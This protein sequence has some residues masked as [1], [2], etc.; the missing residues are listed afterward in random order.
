MMFFHQVTFTPDAQDIPKLEKNMYSINAFEYNMSLYTYSY[1]GYGLMA[2]RKEILTRDS[3][4]L[5]N[6]INPKEVVEV[7]SEC[8]NPIVTTEWSYSGVDYLVRGPVNGSHKLVKTQNFGGGDEDRPIVRFKKCLDII[9]AYVS[10]IPHK[11]IG[12]NKHEVYAFSY[13]FERATEVRNFKIKKLKN[14]NKTNF[15]IF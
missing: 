14:T 10:T 7:R 13:Y 9:E 6:E 5:S 2:A 15:S 3:V 4:L 12:L 8:V 11:P 1:L